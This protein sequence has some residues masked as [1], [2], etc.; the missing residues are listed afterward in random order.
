MFNRASKFHNSTSCA[1]T[2][3]LVTLLPAIR[4]TGKTALS[5]IVDG[6]PD[7]S[8]KHLLNLLS[9]GRLWCDGNLDALLVTTHAPGSSAYNKVEH[10]WSLM[11]RSL[12]GVTFSIHLPGERPPCEQGLSEEETSR[13]ESVVFDRALDQRDGYWNG[14]TYDGHPVTSSHVECLVEE[15]YTDHDVLDAF[16]KSSMAKIK[17]SPLLSAVRQRLLFFCKHVTRT[18]YQL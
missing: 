11:S 14:K 9:C 10:A 15:H 4:Q 6:G 2:S 17:E 18:R 12:T 1:H 7:Q 5:C 13:K 3:A 8:P 16:V